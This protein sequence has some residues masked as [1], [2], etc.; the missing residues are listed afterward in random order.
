MR[1]ACYYCS[2][3]SL[4]NSWSCCGHKY[5]AKMDLFNAYLFIIFKNI[6]YR[7]FVLLCR[8]L[9]INQWKVSIFSYYNMVKPYLLTS[10][11]YN[12]FTGI[13]LDVFKNNTVRRFL[14][15]LFSI[16]ISWNEKNPK[17]RVPK[18]TSKHDDNVAFSS[19]WVICY[20]NKFNR[21]LPYA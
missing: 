11:I 10:F 5:L 7:Y 18:N 12:I 16:H 20:S 2:I 14:S 13:L 8:L 4:G 1:T 6:K 17:W 15:T 9:E 19:K 21:Q 3:V